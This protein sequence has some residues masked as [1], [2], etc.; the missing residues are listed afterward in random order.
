MLPIFDMQFDGTGVGM[1]L[2]SS[3]QRACSVTNI[4]FV[5]AT[6]HVIAFV[7]VNYMVLILQIASASWF[8]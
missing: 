6:Y 3:I 4:G 5:N 2:T 1:L 7:L 8:D